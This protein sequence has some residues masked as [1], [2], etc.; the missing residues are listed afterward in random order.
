MCPFQCDLCHFRNIQLRDP[1]PDSKL[2]MN[3]LVAIRRANLDAFWGRSKSTVGHNR[4]GFKQ[5]VELANSKYGITDI[6]PPMGPHPLRDDWKMKSA[7]VL[8]RKSLDKG[9]NADTVQFST[10]RKLRS[11]FSNAWGS[12]IHTMTSCC[13]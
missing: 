13:C 10:A 7:V 8:L 1:H 6:L 4:G 9:K 11:A 5:L 3:L 2:D 12:S